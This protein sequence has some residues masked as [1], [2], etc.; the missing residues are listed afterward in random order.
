MTQNVFQ[1]LLAR[2]HNFKDGCQSP[3]TARRDNQIRLRRLR[4]WL[5]LLRRG[6][7]SMPSWAR[8]APACLLLHHSRNLFPRTETRMPPATSTSEW[9]LRVREILHRYDP[10]RE[11]PLGGYLTL[12]GIFA[13]TMTTA[14]SLTSR[15]RTRSRLE[16]PQL[17]LL[18]V[19]TFQLARLIAKDRVLA[20]LRAPF[21][22][23]QDS[24]SAGEVHEEARG[25]GLQRAIG[26]LVTCP[27]CLAPWVASALSIAV[28]AAPRKTR[29]FAGVVAVTAI[30]DA[31]Q[32]LY[33]GLRKLS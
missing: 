3:S 7:A 26:E 30:A 12:L 25:V 20:P 31:C 2:E 33:A 14:L 1:H 5:A 6:S 16:P 23:F 15:T 29:W 8:A 18:G 9:T 28:I 19:S 11:L 13:A 24:S 32:Q 27:Y 22:K 21:T 4:A 17:L 10:N